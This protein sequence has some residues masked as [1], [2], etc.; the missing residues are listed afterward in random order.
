MDVVVCRAVQETLGQTGSRACGCILSA[1]GLYSRAMTNRFGL[2]LPP[3]RVR[4]AAAESVSE[5]VIAEWHHRQEA[6][7]AVQDKAEEARRQVMLDAIK[8]LVGS[9]TVSN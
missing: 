3:D 8:S 7:E 4:W 2:D 5:D 1:G 9:G 6:S